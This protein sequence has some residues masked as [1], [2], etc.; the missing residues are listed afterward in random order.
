MILPSIK[1]RSIMTTAQMLNCIPE[2]DK[3][4]SDSRDTSTSSPQSS[5]NNNYVSSPQTSNGNMNNN[6][7][8][9]NRNP[10]TVIPS[11]LCVVCGDKAIGKHYGAVAC[12]GC[13]GFFRRSVWQNL[14]YTCRFNKNC[15]VDKDHRN[16]CRFCRFQKCLADGMKPEAIQNERDRIGSTKRSRKR[17]FTLSGDGDLSN[18]GPSF[19]YGSHLGGWG[20]GMGSERCSPIDLSFD[21]SRQYIENI[22]NVDNS[23]PLSTSE[24]N[25]QLTSRQKCIN[26]IISWANKLSP[27]NQLSVDDKIIIL[28]NF[29]TPFSLVNTLQK[30][31]NSAHIVLPDDQILS[32][33]SFYN[34][35]VSNIISKILDELLAPLRRIHLEKAE[36]SVLKAL[37]TFS[38]DISGISLSAKEKLREATDTLLKSF[39]TCLTQTYSGVEASLRISSILLLIPSFISV[40]RIIEKNPLLGQLFGVTDINSNQNN[41]STISINPTSST[42]NNSITNVSVNGSMIQQMTSQSHIVPT[43]SPNLMEAF[44]SSGTSSFFNGFKNDLTNSTDINSILNP[45][46]LLS[47][48]LMKSPENLFT[49]D[50]SSDYKNAI[51]A[52]ML[53]N[54]SSNTNNSTINSNSIISSLANPNSSV[55]NHIFNNYN[56]SAPG[57]II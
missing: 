46:S 24:N 37:I 16:A 14:Q 29:S 43:S 32:L 5:S 36:F 40:G 6:N 44:S 3:S 52:N 7:N 56:R 45:A 48:K 25:N 19:S 54:A 15:N 33:S 47:N 27:I 18:R 4:N 9:N 53:A 41:P 50:K 30:S 35:E 28:K 11:D 8:N 49:T 51:L 12:N 1:D 57:M 17:E 10:Q 34:S 55:A 26:Q 39:F 23:I 21:A 38:S 31:V 20:T 42:A 22:Y 13:K 2:D